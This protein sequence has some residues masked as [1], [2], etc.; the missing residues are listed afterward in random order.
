M[1]GRKKRAAVN[2]AFG[3]A[4]Q[5]VTAVMSFILRSVFILKLS[6]TLLGV[7]AVYT[8]VLTL[9]SMAELGIGTALG[10]S[11]YSPVAEKDTDTVKS[12]MLFYRRAYRYIALMVAV[13]GLV[14]IPFLPVICKNS[15]GLSRNELTLYYLIFLFNTVSTYFV[16]YKY[17]LVN[18]EQKNYIQTNI[19]TI[20]KVITVFFQILVLLF[21]SIL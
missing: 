1:S 20:T 7:N 10:Y 13:I 21:R 2:I 3:Y 6:E 16:S 5:L 11:L 4:G 14:L 12:Y 8:N 19:N 17:S 9:L 18:A 15:V